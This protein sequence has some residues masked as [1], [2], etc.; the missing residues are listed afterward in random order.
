MP[1]P[2]IRQAAAS[3]AG[4]GTITV[5]LGASMAIG[6]LL[7]IFH[8][9]DFG[10]AAAME[11][12]AGSQALS[13]LT[14]QATSDM[15]TNGVHM[16]LWTAGIT[17]AGAQNVTLTIGT[18]GA[19]TGVSVLVLDGSTVDPANFLDGVATAGNVSAASTSLAAAA[20]SPST[21]NALLACGVVGAAATAVARSYTPP[22]GMTEQVD[23]QDPNLWIA[24]TDATQAL[25]AAGSTG[26]KTF[27][28]SPAAN[29]AS[30]SV[31][32]KGR[33]SGV[34]PMLASYVGP[35]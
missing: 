19:D 30:V 33:P 14:T 15:G 35:G 34:T 23:M 28:V 25:T 5:S 21:S 18:S 2:A 20:V 8:G 26:T 1:T 32:V 29:F 4:S 9:N 31:A 22:T 13:N 6:D 11:T 7:L 10:T 3:A 24:I 16:R 27:T 12:P 17:V